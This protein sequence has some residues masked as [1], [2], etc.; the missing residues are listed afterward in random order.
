MINVDIMVPSIEQEFDFELD[1]SARI[2]GIIEE[3]VSMISQK[4]QSNIAG[5]SSELMLCAL[6]DSVVLPK[7]RTLRQCGITN[8]CRLM[9][10]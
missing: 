9:L 7:N 6:Q 1:E 8:G 5:E 4:I 2:S 10:I 3:T